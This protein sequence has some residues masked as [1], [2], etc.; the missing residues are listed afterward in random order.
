MVRY[1]T[2]ASAVMFLI[3]APILPAIEEQPAHFIRP[4]SV[5]L[6]SGDYRPLKNLVG[7]NVI[8]SDNFDGEFPGTKWTVSVSMPGIN[9]D[10]YWGKTSFEPSTGSTGVSNVWCAASGTQAANPATDNYRDFMNTWMIAGPFDLSSATSGDFYLDYWL[11]T[12][13][14]YDFFGYGISID[15][16]NFW[17]MVTSGN[18]S[19][20]KQGSIDLTNVPTLGN[21]TGQGAVY[22]ACNFNSDLFTSDRG[23]FVDGVSIEVDSGSPTPTSTPTPTPSPTPQSGL[24]IGTGTGAPFQ[25]VSIPVTV[26]QVSDF[27]AFGFDLQYD[28]SKLGYN[29]LQKGT[30]TSSWTQVSGQPVSGGVRIGGYV[31]QG[32]AVNAAGEICRVQLQVKTGA[33]PGGDI[34]LTAI[35][36][37]D[38][39]AGA[40]VTNGKVTPDCSQPTPSPTPTPPSVSLE[41]IRDHIVAK[42]QLSPSDQ[43]IAD[44][45]KDSRIDS[46][47][48]VKYV[49]LYYMPTPTPTVT[50]SSLTLNIGTGSA[51]PSQ[52]ATVPVTVDNIS[53]GEA[54]GFD[55]S[56]DTAKLSFAGVEKGGATNTWYTVSGTPITGGIRVGGFAG[57]GSAVTGSAREICRLRFQ[58]NQQA[59]SGGDVILTASNLEDDLKGAVL[60]NGKV[61]PI[62]TG[63]GLTLEI[64]NASGSPSEIVEI[65][66]SVD[67][68]TGARSFG[69]ELRFD[70]TKLAYISTVKGNSLPDW[71]AID[72]CGIGGGVR[73]GGFAGGG[74]SLSGSEREICRVR[75]Q[76]NAACPAGTEIPLSALNLV[77]GLSG[78]AVSGG[79][80]S[81]VCR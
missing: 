58:V 17:G 54:F 11:K 48:M 22:I 2:I 26:N 70:T 32:T 79:S 59:C 21:V 81:P 29:G 62:C 3:L 39:L 53:G 61:T 4:E 25:T 77:D 30:A 16:S 36:L 73:I 46:G 27:R 64:G 13:L 67:N 68:A 43:T 19:G 5:P 75:L 12:E 47:D 31:G 28:T 52:I 78:A 76:I 10:A 35:T 60:T 50:P 9:T 56:F 37:V 65:P 23:V 6:P 8:F 45:N 71:A 40:A 1:I 33:C 41:M 72:G 34:P 24:I 69:F 14:D 20:W 15:G 7:A 51:A 42:S 74:M 55:I 44:C 57:S 66:I 18:S 63:G 38:D 49:D 80:V